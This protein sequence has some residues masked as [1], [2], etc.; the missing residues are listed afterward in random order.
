MA[1]KSDSKTQRDSEKIILSCMES[2]M[3]LKEG[4]LVSEK[5]RLNDKVFIEID[6][7]HEEEGIMVEV[8]SR[9]GKPKPAHY[10]KIANDI[11]KLVM[12]EKL[13]ETKYRKILAVCDDSVEK[14]LL[15][16]S[17]KAH[18]VKVFDF[19]VMNVKI[20]DELKSE[21]MNAQEL[22]NQGNK[23]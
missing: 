15:G 23:L 18:A 5:I 8:F 19:E 7:F 2:I 22:Q 9:I 11:L 17:W 1:H 16:N 14:Y 12:V 3:N 4:S 20:P 6:G 13:H 21:I 10:E